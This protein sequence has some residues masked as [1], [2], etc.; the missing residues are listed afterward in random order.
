VEKI[1]LEAAFDAIQKFAGLKVANMAMLRRIGHFEGLANH[2]NPE[3]KSIGQRLLGNL[4]RTPPKPIG[5]QINQSLPAVTSAPKAPP[6]A[7]FNG[8]RPGTNLPKPAE[9]QL[10]QSAL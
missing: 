10:T 7:T 8:V 3:L 6:M 2:S 1:A 4:Q 9:F 5:P